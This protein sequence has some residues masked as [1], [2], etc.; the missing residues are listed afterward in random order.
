MSP[1]VENILTLANRDMAAGRYGDAEREYSR[2]LEQDPELYT[3]LHSR[4]VAR[5][6]RSTLLDGDPVAL[7]AS[8]Q[9]ALRMCEKAGGDENAFLNR[10]AIDLI[11]LT[12]TKYNELTRIYVSIARKENQKAPSPLFFY[13]WSLSHSQG[14][15]LTDIY[16]PLI[17]Y[18]AAI[19]KVSEYLDEL[20]K[21]KKGLEHRRLHN[22]GNLETFYDWLIAFNATGRV[23]EEYYNETVTKK[24][25]LQKLRAQLEEAT[26]APEFQNV[27]V[28]TSD[29]RPLPGVASEVDVARKVA[30]YGVRPP[31]EV[32][33]PICGTMQKSNRSICFQCAC[34]FFFDDEIAE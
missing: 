1:S 31:F 6:W 19:I 30:H 4:G 5:T 32:I 26:N 7:I 12:S 13:T 27:P 16:I 17:N 11:N 33:C 29:G 8:T 22:V 34:K 15:T 21:D 14:L 18:L 10:V 20:L 3:A 24:A 2:A 25:Y 9:D 23:Q 28:G